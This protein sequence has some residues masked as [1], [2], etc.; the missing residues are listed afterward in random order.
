MEGRLRDFDVII[1]GNG[2]HTIVDAAKKR[3]F[4]TSMRTAHADSAIQSY[5]KQLGYLIPVFDAN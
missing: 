3:W 2:V 5:K 1:M 4:G